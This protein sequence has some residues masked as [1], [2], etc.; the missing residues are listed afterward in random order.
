ML[1]AGSN[2]ALH[3]RPEW[4]GSLPGS[5]IAWAAIWVSVAFL[6]VVLQIAPHR[7]RRKKRVADEDL[8]DDD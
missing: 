1:G 4:E 2:L 6:G 3:F 7:K 8:E 5:P